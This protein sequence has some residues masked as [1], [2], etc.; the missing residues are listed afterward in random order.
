MESW[1]V[2]RQTDTPNQA[3]YASTA[4]SFLI[5]SCA[6]NKIVGSIWNVDVAED[7][8]RMEKVT[9]EEVVARANE[10]RS[11]LKTIW[12]R[13]HRRLRHVLRH[14]N[15]LH[16][17]TEG[18]WWTRGYLGRKRMEYNRR[19][20]LWTVERFNLTENK[21]ETGQQV[22]KHARNLLETAED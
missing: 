3:I 5:Y 15:L 22:R 16:D 9:N 11:I 20:W 6:T 13:K 2:E 12:C 21:M 8:G 14:D 10:A 18:K 4:K 17:I 19:K 7:V 1:K